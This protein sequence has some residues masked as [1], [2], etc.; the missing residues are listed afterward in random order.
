MP[1]VE[2]ANTSVVDALGGLLLDVG[3]VNGAMEMLQRS[4]HLAPNDNASKYMYLG[5]VQEGA[6]AVESFER[7]ITIMQREV[8]RLESAA[9]TSS[10][11]SER[12]Q[13]LDELRRAL[14]SG[15]CAIAEVL[16]PDADTAE[17]IY[18]RCERALQQAQQVRR[19]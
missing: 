14:C 10:D 4:I 11:F 2:P 13:Q 7:G 18:T 3:D 16:L 1:Q 17:Q 6:E 9:Q 15:H 8:T 5:Q 12:R 19:P